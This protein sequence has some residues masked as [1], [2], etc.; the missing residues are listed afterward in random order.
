VNG[1]LQG[2]EKGLE[3]PHQGERPYK[4]HAGENRGSRG[5]L[6]DDFDTLWSLRG[7]ANLYPKAAIE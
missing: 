5:S 4:L 6:K 3:F 2:D 7:I 1:A